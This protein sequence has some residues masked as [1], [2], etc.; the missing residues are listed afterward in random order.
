[1]SLEP[2]SYHVRN[3]LY[4]FLTLRGA[5]MDAGKPAWKRAFPRLSRLRGLTGT[6]TQDKPAQSRLAGMMPAPRRT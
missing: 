2:F 6:I 4:H 1:M 3:A 5:G